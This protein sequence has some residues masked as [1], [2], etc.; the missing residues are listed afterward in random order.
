MLGQ[1]RFSAPLTRVTRHSQAFFHTSS[2]PVWVG[3]GGPGF[4]C[5]PRMEQRPNMG[6]MGARCHVQLQIDCI[7]YL[8]GGNVTAYRQ[9]CRHGGVTLRC[10]PALR[11]KRSCSPPWT[12]VPQQSNILPLH[13]PT[14][15]PSPNLFAA[16]V[17]SGRQGH[18]SL[19][20]LGTSPSLG[21]SCC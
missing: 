15:Q 2:A 12:R 7:L 8:C 5:M 13:A 20:R 18:C 14:T 11:V 4:P 1:A 21:T 19:F 10:L 16:A 9:L 3:L 17:F 6:L